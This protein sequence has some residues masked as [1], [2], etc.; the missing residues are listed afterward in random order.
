M[1]RLLVRILLIDDNATFVAAFSDMLNEAAL[2]CPVQLSTAATEKEALQSLAEKPPDIVFLSLDDTD[3]G[4]IGIIKKIKHVGA[5]IPVI[6]ITDYDHEAAAL[7]AIKNGAMDYFF[8]NGLAVH[9]LVHIVRFAHGNRH[10][11]DKLKRTSRQ[12]R[13]TFDSI[14]DWI[15]ILD[16][17]CGIIRVNK[18]F[19]GS[20]GRHPRDIIGANCR[21]LIGGVDWPCEECPQ[22]IVIKSGEPRVTEIFNRRLWLHQVITTAPFLDGRGRIVGASHVVK[23]VTE[24][25]RADIERETLITG[26][27]EALFKVKTLSGLLPICASCKQIRDDKGNWNP[28]E[29]YVRDRSNAQFSHGI[30]PEC[31][32][33][34]YPDY[35]KAR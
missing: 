27:R 11:Q 34:L 22:H 25:K 6:V 31:T 8:K 2:S 23:D 5:L 24:K 18:A 4:W 16:E 10:N 3:G 32:K 33:K 9:D 21:G 29:T 14:P 35:Y 15:M 13:A 7:Q 17:G 30:C 26:L 28:I 20:L 19:A 1:H 12:W